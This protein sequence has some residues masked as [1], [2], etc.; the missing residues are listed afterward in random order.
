MSILAKFQA[1]VPNY[2][3]PPKAPLPVRSIA[4]VQI[5]ELRNKLTAGSVEWSP[6]LARVLALPRREKPDCEALA[7]ELTARLKTPHGTMKLRPIQAWA[8]WEGAQ[9]GGLFGSIAVGAGKEVLGLL[10]PMV[11]PSCKRAVLLIPPALRT[12]LLEF[13]WPRYA[14]HWV[15]PNLAGG[16][17]F[18][19]GKPVLH[20][21]SY[22]EVSNPKHPRLLEQIQPDLIIANECHQIRYKNASRTKRALRYFASNHMTRF[23]G[24]S[25]TVTSNSLRDYAH[26]IALALGEQSPLPLH[27]PTV[28]EWA[29]ALDANTN[30]QSFSAGKLRT[31]CKPGE[32]V[33]SGFRRRLVDTPGVVATGENELGVSLVFYERKSPVVPQEVL[34]HLKKLRKSPEEGGWIRPDGEELVDALR[35][36]ACARELAMGFFYRWRFPKGEPEELILEWFSRRQDWNRELRKKLMRGRAYLDS[37][38]LCA[39]AARRFYE[40]GCSECN[41]P[42]LGEHDRNCGQA[43]SRPIWAAGSW[44]A[45]SAIEEAVYHESEAVWLS[46]F[47]VEDAA[48]WA[49]EAPGIVWA[50]HDALGKRLAAHSKMPYYGGGKEASLGIMNEA[51]TRSIIA[52]MKAHGTGKNLQAFNRNL[53]T[54]TPSDAALIEQVVGRT[55][56]T[57]Q[58]ADEVEVY[59]YAH[60]EEMTD[61]LIKAH[62][63]ARY[64]GKTTGSVQKMCYGNWVR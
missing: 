6:D 36:N 49:E 13:D 18:T 1:I 47:L 39:S 29:A 62:E 38:H 9:V 28:D 22:S 3:P 7:E 51:G 33:R 42:A 20:I 4:S 23:C 27:P 24:W 16:S 37:P 59:Y 60:T 10:M 19:P 50:E 25:G 11:M 48:A 44:P 40:G 53:I 61:A 58:K 45:W 35:V 63:K 2:V 8:L 64:I 34:A 46:D 5:E 54:A 31:L 26:L 55:H 21:V 30:G 43:E 32:D 56:R 12:Q 15:L 17:R 52:S 41:R 57:G 14:E